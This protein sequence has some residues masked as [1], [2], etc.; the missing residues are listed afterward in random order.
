MHLIEKIKNFSPGVKASIA[1]FIASLIT[2]GISYVTMPIYIRLL[3]ADEYGQVSVFLTWLEVFGIVAM[4]CLSYG[5]FNNGMIDYQEKRDEFSFSLL[6]LSNIITACFTGAIIFLYPIISSWIKVDL[7]LLMLMCFIF[8]C[9]PAYNFWT[10]RQRYEYK[11]KGVFFWSIICVF[12]SSM[13]AF[14]CILINKEGSRLYARIFGS[15]L[16][17]IVIYIGFYIHLGI[18]A[19]FRIEK[20]YWKAALLFNLPLIPHYL[21]TYLLGSADKLMISNII[22]DTATAYYSVAY[23][24]ASIALVV[25]SAINSSLIPYTYSCCK[26]K[27][28]K[29]INRVTLPILSVF[30]VACMAV[31]L[32]APEVVALVA[33][34]NYYEAIFVIPPIVG[35]VF[36]QVQYFVY[37]NVVYYFKKPKYVMMGSITAVILN[38]ILNYIFITKYG[39]IAAG[40]T[41]IFCYFVQAVIDYFAMRK[42]VGES[43]YNMKFIVLLSI[44]IIVIVFS[45]GI[46][47]KYLFTRYIILLGLIALVFISRKKLINIVIEMKGI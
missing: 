2:R 40:Y 15:E 43:I 7:P 41:T 17:L 20:K 10:A 27:K 29:L 1:F 44:T 31:L 46:L 12:L 21:S 39:Y 11:Y 3:T 4:F 37:A 22:G 42:V 47:Y 23:S 38:I 13:I 30:A 18:R 19:N 32:L 5:V 6:V 28:Y 35:G 34:K 9:Q 24:V 26:E 36:F 33:T 8:F 45:S 16:T 25:W 14:I